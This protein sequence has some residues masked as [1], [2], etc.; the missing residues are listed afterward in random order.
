M[1]RRL[2]LVSEAE[3]ETATYVVHAG[4][5][6][7]R[8][9]VG[10][11]LVE[12]RDADLRHDLQADLERNVE[13]HARAQ[14][15]LAAGGDIEIVAG[16]DRRADPDAEEE[17]WSGPFPSRIDIDPARLTIGSEG[18][19]EDWPD[20]ATEQRQR[21]GEGKLGIEADPAFSAAGSDD[22]DVM[23]QHAA[24]DLVQPGLG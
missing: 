4:I 13:E 20:R 23:R 7:G 3:G 8:V 14:R 6:K 17:Q 1:D 2:A 16:L 10:D 18:G 12:G 11:V 19:P 5:G 22:R 9:A 24:S 15:L 21:R